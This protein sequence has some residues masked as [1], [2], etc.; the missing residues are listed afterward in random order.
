[1]KEQLLHGHLFVTLLFFLPFKK[2]NEK[3]RALKTHQNYTLY[4]SGTHPQI[5]GHFN[6]SA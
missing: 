3:Y 1:M 5:R 2:D 4:P 6:S